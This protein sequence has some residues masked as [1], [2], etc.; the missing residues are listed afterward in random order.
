MHV[1]TLQQEAHGV[2]QLAD[3]VVLVRRRRCEEDEAG[4]V[5]ETE[6]EEGGMNQGS[7]EAKEE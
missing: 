7:K 3:G 6:P 4:G 1:L 2:A 5:R